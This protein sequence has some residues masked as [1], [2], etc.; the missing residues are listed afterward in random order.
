MSFL[1]FRPYDF[2][3]LLKDISKLNNNYSFVHVYEIG[4]SVE[5]RPIW[6]IKIGEGERKVHFNGSF[7]ANEWITS[8]ALMSFVKEYAEAVDQDGEIEGVSS[9]FLFSETALSIVPM[10][11]PDGVELVINGP[12]KANAQQVMAMNHGLTDFSGWKANIRGVDLNNQYPV[13]WEIEKERK[14]PKSPAAR[15]Y[16]GDRPLSEPEA[17]VM[18]ELQ[19]REQFDRVLAFHTQGAE[20]YW[21]YNNKE[22]EESK[23]LAERFERVSGYEAV[24]FIDSHAGFKDW[25]IQEYERPGFTIELGKGCNPLPLTQLAAVYEATRSI[26][27]AALLK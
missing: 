15:D 14:L 23:Q 9:Q 1:C 7:H 18:A 17:I 11:N 6:E 19:M 8:S 26:C 5:G 25:F 4:K 10:V 27:I 22:P 12:S 2:Q 3:Q 24:H 13:G 16:P 20:F 21:G